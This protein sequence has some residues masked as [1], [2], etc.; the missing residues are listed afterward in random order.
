MNRSLMVV[1]H[2]LLD[3][4]ERTD[5][6][7]DPDVVLHARKAVSAAPSTA[8]NFYATA[9]PQVLNT[10]KYALTEMEPSEDDEVM[11]LRWRV[12]RVLSEYVGEPIMMK[13]LPEPSEEEHEEDYTSSSHNSKL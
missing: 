4:E 12:A 1:A 11:S 5:H 9:E 10:F 6:L 8:V 7:L 2:A 13:E 3:L